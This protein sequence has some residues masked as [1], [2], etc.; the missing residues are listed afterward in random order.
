MIKPEILAP[1]GSRESV[2]AA[3]N[4]GCDAIYIGGSKFGAR[5]YADNP[6]STELEEIITDC[7]LSGVK[8]FITVNTLYKETELN[9]VID[10]IKQVYKYGAYGLIIQDIGLARIVKRFFPDIKISASTQMT[11]HNTEGLELMKKLGFNRVVLARELNE[12]EIKNICDKKGS[13]EV[14][15]FI[16]GALCVCYSGR[17]LMSSFIGGRSGNRGRCAQPCR[18]EY[19]LVKNDKAIKKGYL[20][21]PRDISTID[22]L[23]RVVHTGLDSLKIEGRMKSPEYVYQTV[24]TYRKYLDNIFEN[25]YFGNIDKLDYK[26]LTQIFNRGGK[27]AHGYFDSYSGPDMITVETPKSSGV[28]IGVVENYNYTKR[29]CTIKLFDDVTAG[30]GIEIWSKPHTGCGINYAAKKGDIISVKVDGKIKKGDRVFKSYDKKLNDD[31]KSKMSANTKKLNIDISFKLKINEPVELSLNDYPIKVYSKS[32][33]EKAKKSPL[34]AEDVSKRLMKTGSTKYKFNVV[35]YDIDDNVFV[36]VSVLN[37]LKREACDKLYEYQISKLKRDIPS[38][39]YKRLPN[40]EKA[41]KTNITVLVNT[42]DQFKAAL[43]SN[44]EI[45]YCSIL[46]EKYAD[47]ALNCNKQFYYALP[48]ISRDGYSKYINKL[49]KTSCRGYIV[50]SYGV[51]NTEKE[52][53]TDYSL[54]IM[55]SSALDA[56]REIFSNCKRVCLSTEL[57]LNE[58][59]LIAGKDCEVVVYGRLPLMTTHQCPAGL[60]DGCKK[61]GKFCKLKNSE[62]TYVLRDRKNVEFP[63]IRDCENCIAYILNSAPIHTIDTLSKIQSIGAGYNRVELTIENY[64]QSLKIINSYV[65]KT[66]FEICGSTRGHFYRGVE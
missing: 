45:I 18:T 39:E 10:F 60:Y 7:Y 59:E 44:A 5:A 26:N 20:L 62:D 41:E 53:I 65:D 61:S 2:E 50:R 57:R 54:N 30:D 46:D 16:H 17:C 55:N 47:V 4:A 58:A 14:E 64:E 34:T 19:S 11:I 40:T 63:I 32:V 27:S 13:T 33:A 51:I 22:V 12:A 36:P 29:K 25:K 56:V 37:D 43:D 42:K 35:D 38:Y 8:T 48:Y 66:P 23:D 3:I 6:N 9:E 31:L 15:G 49:D 52:V 1:T 21:S 24:S 28:E